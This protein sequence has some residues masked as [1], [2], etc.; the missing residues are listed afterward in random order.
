MRALLVDEPE[1]E[2]REKDRKPGI[3]KLMRKEREDIR[4]DLRHHLSETLQIIKKTD[5]CQ[6]RTDHGIPSP[7]KFLFRKIRHR[8][9]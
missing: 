1:K 8:K 5:S 9:I 4:D 7:E 2:R 6:F 3:K